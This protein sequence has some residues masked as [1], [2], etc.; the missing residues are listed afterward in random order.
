MESVPDTGKMGV[1]GQQETPNVHFFGLKSMTLGT[2]R[3]RFQTVQG[4]LAGD[5]DA[6]FWSVEVC[7]SAQG[8]RCLAYLGPTAV[9]TR[10]GAGLPRFPLPFSLLCH[11][12]N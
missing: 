4:N 11:T 2:S 9:R 1:G 7:V 10:V 3:L 6:P 8:L 12:T 5:P